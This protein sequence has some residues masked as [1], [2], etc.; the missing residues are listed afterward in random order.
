MSLLKRPLEMTLD[1]R[2]NRI[3]WFTVLLVVAAFL[4]AFSFVLYDEQ[5]KGVAAEE[6]F[7][8]QVMHVQEKAIE[9]EIFLNLDD[10][11][12]IRLDGVVANERLK[13][14]HMRACVRVVPIKNPD[15]GDIVSCSDPSDARRFNSAD[16]AYAEQIISIGVE[17]MA[18]LQHFLVKDRSWED[19][20]P[21]KL[22]VSIVCAVIGAFFLHRHA[23]RN[24][25]RNVVAPL[26]R[27]IAEDERSTAIAQTVQMVAHDFRKPFLALRTAINTLQLAKNQAD[28]EALRAKCMPDLEKSIAAVN[29]LLADVLEFGSTRKSE[30]EESSIT[31]AIITAFRTLAPLTS[32]L[33]VNLSYSFHH[34]RKVS[35]ESKHVSRIVSNLVENAFQA[36]NEGGQIWF[37]SREITSADKRFIEISIGNSGSYIDPENLQRIFE[38]FVTTKK[39]GYGLG[40]AIASKFVREYGGSIWAN[41]SKETGTQFYFTL[42]VGTEFEPYT[43]EQLPKKLDPGYV[44]TTNDVRPAKN[45]Q[46]NVN[47]S[48]SILL[49]DD[50]ECVRQAW[51]ILAT[52]TGVKNLKPFASWEDFISQNGFDLAAGATA[53][54]DINFRGSK[55]SG[56][57]IA[58]N[59][60]RL[61][62][63]R[64]YAITA[65]PKV[66]IAS[67][68]FDEVLGKDFPIHLTK[69]S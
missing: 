14:A 17:P 3:T 39:T 30:P 1:Q 10:A 34:R 62:I 56:L 26:L 11:I 61:G 24:L 37:Q 35:A 38:P 53:F 67:G 2:L 45:T 40:L 52:K 60:R 27:N 23:V 42:P 16:H 15:A 49:F 58:N 4:V 29:S 43:D 59:L 55:F 46:I 20:V 57:E 6:A 5:K 13:A 54:V 22:L 68:L 69:A 48:S 28:Y 50:E 12:K 63:S 18:K 36:V 65:D 25:Q 44:I 32:S 31:E 19:F 41:S 21:P 47:G 9:Q 51:L 64:L 7:L 33:Q 66:A 8:A